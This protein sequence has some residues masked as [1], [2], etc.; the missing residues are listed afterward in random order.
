MADE[1]GEAKAAGKAA[2]FG[3]FDGNPIFAAYFKEKT[4]GAL[5]EDQAGKIVDSGVNGALFG[6]MR[7]GSEQEM[8]D[9][10]VPLVV[11]KLKTDEKSVRINNDTLRQALA[12]YGTIA[13]IQKRKKNPDWYPPLDKMPG[14]RAVGSDLIGR[15]LVDMLSKSETIG[16]FYEAKTGGPLT[17]QK[18]K[19]AGEVMFDTMFNAELIKRVK[20]AGGGQESYKILVDEV[21]AGLKARKSELPLGDD[22]RV[23]RAFAENL[24]AEIMLRQVNPNFTPSIAMIPATEGLAKEVLAGEMNKALDKEKEMF[25][26]A[27]K[28]NGGPIDRVALVDVAAGSMA[29]LVA[30]PRFRKQNPELQRQQLSVAIAKGIKDKGIIAND[31]VTALLSDVMASGVTGKLN[32]GAK[33]LPIDRKLYLDVLDD[34]VPKMLDDGIAAYRASG[35]TL[36]AGIK[37]VLKP[38]SVLKNAWDLI[39]VNVADTVL[40]LDA[41]KKPV[42]DIIKTVLHSSEFHKLDDAKK[43]EHLEKMI[44]GELNRISRQDKGSTANALLAGSI[45]SSVSDQLIPRLGD[46]PAEVTADP[47]KTANDAFNITRE[48]RDNRDQLV[49]ELRVLASLKDDGERKQYLELKREKYKREFVTWQKYDQGHH[50]P[51]EEEFQ[52]I[53]SLKD[54]PMLAAKYVDLRPFDM[55]SKPEAKEVTDLAAVMGQLNWNNENKKGK[56]GNQRLMDGTF[57]WNRAGKADRETG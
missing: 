57:L 34:L 13:I 31:H 36:V 2:L 11:Q 43:K 30:D 24:A 53:T 18:A 5:T 55:G 21:E 40:D 16:Q 41:A 28:A 3:V 10:V 49:K 42:G 33:L 20:A 38:S 29:R 47:A 37:T 48:F 45:A 50:S 56:T 25:G 51:P 4:G 54:I 17:P 46:I 26:L 9:R 7:G 8:Y 19:V 32:K 35:N 52:L 14:L 27:E 1:I 15:T 44:V 6:L 22:P 12:E 23:G 39:E